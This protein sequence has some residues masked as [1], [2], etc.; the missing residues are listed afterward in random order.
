M[1][2][3]AK[4]TIAVIIAAILIFV[5]AVALGSRL[6]EIADNTESIT[7]PSTTAPTSAPKMPVILAQARPLSIPEHTDATTAPDSTDETTAPDSTDETTAPDTTEITTENTTADESLE[8]PNN[9][10][11]SYNAVSVLLRS[12]SND[13]SAILHYSSPISLK[14]ALASDADVD[15]GAALASFPKDEYVSGVFALSFPSASSAEKNLLREYELSLLCEI[16]SYGI[17]EI[18]LLG[19]SS[20]PE[21]LAEANNFV[22][23]LLSREDAT[24]LS[25]G[26]ALSHELLETKNAKEV[27]R[28]SGITKAFL[29]LDLYTISVPELMTDE[30]FIR[31]KLDKCADAISTYNMRILLGCGKSPNLEAQVRTA[32]EKNIYNIQ[33]ILKTQRTENNSPSSVF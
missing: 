28:A 30:D 16:A 2:G 4:Y 11:I 3:W 21:G 32:L 26:I 7:L 8:S 20:D 27:L 14:Y 24:G 18:V 19:F 1:N 13:G 22:I 33:E 9:V 17:D 5:F 12:F 29:A 10:T 23:E 31:N 25:V 6:G 15:L